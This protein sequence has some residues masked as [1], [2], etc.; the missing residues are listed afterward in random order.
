M[1]HRMHSAAKV[2]VLGVMLVFA[3]C[4]GDPGPQGAQGPAGPAGEPARGDVYC[5]SA[6]DARSPTW[7]I[8]AQCD[9]AA[10]IPLDGSCAANALPA[11]VNLAQNG[12]V[13]WEFADTRAGWECSWLGTSIPD[14]LVG[15]T[16]KMCCIAVGPRPTALTLEAETGQ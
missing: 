10:D 11:G 8:V 16:V 3:G 5:R 14:P 13:N 1:R 7:R 4:E 9:T 15:T 2:G 6:S 12:P